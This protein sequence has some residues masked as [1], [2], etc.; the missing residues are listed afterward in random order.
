MFLRFASLGSG[1]RGNAMLVEFGSTL[2]MVDCGLP[3]K[4]VEQRLRLVGREPQDVTALLVTHEHADHAQGV[5]KFARRYNTP[6]WM[7]PGTASAVRGLA[8]VELLSSHRDLTIGEIHVQPYPV[9]HD[10]REPCHFTFGA[11]GR[12]VGVLTDAGHVTPHMIER[13]SPCDAL[14]VEANHDLDSLN[15]GPY[16]ESLKHRVASKFGHLN[17]SQTTALLS[18]LDRARLQWVVGLHL[19]EQ[20]NSPEQVRAALGP[21][22]ANARFPLHLATQDTATAWFALD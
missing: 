1:S 19:S 21:A 14:A 20:N 6:L 8:R 3:L 15:R 22:L 7:T 5:A 12:R 16:P 9:P 2:L 10:A 11:G 13:L 18:R 17:N 4:I